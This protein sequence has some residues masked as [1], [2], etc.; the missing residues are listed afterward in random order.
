MKYESEVLHHVALK[1]T[2][3]ALRTYE[4][5]D[6]PLTEKQMTAVRKAAG[7]KGSGK[8]VSDLFESSTA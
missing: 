3:E 4:P 5:D 2:S 1:L 7:P 8:V 6:G